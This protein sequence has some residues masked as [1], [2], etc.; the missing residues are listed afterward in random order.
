MLMSQLEQ[1]E[2]GSEVWPL[3]MELDCFDGPSTAQ[4]DN[5][6]CSLGSAGTVCRKVT[7]MCVTQGSA[8]IK[9]NR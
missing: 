6:A 9:S 2:R 1:R 5:I 3:K 8:P 4:V 7:Q